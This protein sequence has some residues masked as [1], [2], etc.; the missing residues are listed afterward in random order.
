MLC[1]VRPVRHAGFTLIE[2]LVVISIIAILIG[3]LLPALASARN[4]AYHAACSS[5]LHHIGIATAAYAADYDGRIPYGPDSPLT[6]YSAIGANWSG[7]KW[8]QLATNQTWVSPGLSNLTGVAPNGMLLGLGMLVDNYLENPKA[9]F[10]PSDD[11]QD[12]VEELEKF[13]VRGT[14]P[15]ASAFSSFFYRQLDQTSDDK[16]EWLGNNTAGE[17]AR[18]LVLDANNVDDN[19]QF[20]RTNHNAEDVNILYRDGHVQR[21]DNKGQWFSIQEAH[22]ASFPNMANTLARLD[23][24]FVTA[25]HAQSGDPADAPSP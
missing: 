15:G 23:E 22:N 11:S 17:E 21:V 13:N 2:L 16:L 19:P 6:L 12:P 14:G 18:A 24:I 25:D 1:A 5:N 4:A 10:C 8:N 20:N 3:I 9:L 7:I